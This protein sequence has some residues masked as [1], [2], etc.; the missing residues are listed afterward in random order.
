MNNHQ[1]LF[2]I[3]ARNSWRLLSFSFILI[4]KA[5]I[6]VRYHIA[7]PLRHIA[8]IILCLRHSMPL[9][10]AH[11]NISMKYFNN[12]I[13][14]C[15]SPTT[16]TYQPATITISIQIDI[17]CLAKVLY[18]LQKRLQYDSVDYP[19]YI[20]RCRCKIRRSII[21]FYAVQYKTKCLVKALIKYKPYGVI[22][23]LVQRE[24]VMSCACI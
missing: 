21:F 11:S 8:I 5:V 1:T 24:T 6:L 3:L 9:P 12:K 16:M 23:A 20:R 7:L 10:H 4:S 13:G 14:R 19:K 15:P 2:F 17:F 22:F 18:I